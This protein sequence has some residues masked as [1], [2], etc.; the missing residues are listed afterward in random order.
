MGL[1]RC[2]LP[3]SEHVF[4]MSLKYTLTRARFHVSLNMHSQEDCAG[5]AWATKGPVCTKLRSADFPDREA[6]Y[7]AAGLR[8]VKWT[9]QVAV[10][11]ALYEAPYRPQGM[12]VLFKILVCAAFNY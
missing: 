6:P 12:L 4:H 8:V 11:H 9:G 2:L 7:P 1:P 5:D 10:R 3:L